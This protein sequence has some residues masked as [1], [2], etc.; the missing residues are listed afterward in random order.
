MKRLRKMI[1]ANIGVVEFS[2][3]P[4][5]NRVDRACES[6][7]NS[8]GEHIEHNPIARQGYRKAR[9]ILAWEA[10]RM[11]FHQHINDTGEISRSL[12]A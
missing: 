12:P 2:N 3:L 6:A 9:F 8:I 4:N 5:G 7:I 1:P 10:L 11:R